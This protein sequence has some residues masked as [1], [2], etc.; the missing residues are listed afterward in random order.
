MRRL[1]LLPLLLLLSTALT[2][3]PVSADAVY[4]TERLV[5]APAAGS[6]E[7]GSG[8]VVNAHPNGPR[9]YAH[10][11]YLLRQARPGATYQVH[12]LLG[13]DC[14]SVTSGSAGLVTASITTNAAGNGAA[15]KVFTFAF[16]DSLGIRGMSFKAAWLVSRDGVPAY[17]TACTTITLD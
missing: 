4:Q 14:G 5:L 10:E 7:R 3:G 12:L 2:A 17:R 1:L 8:M 6:G 13:A 16:V 9:I 15:S 11:Q